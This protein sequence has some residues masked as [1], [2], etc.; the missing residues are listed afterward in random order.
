MYIQEK[1]AFS[2]TDWQL[3]RILEAGSPESKAR[4]YKIW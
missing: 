3:G 4:Q 2:Y 1:H